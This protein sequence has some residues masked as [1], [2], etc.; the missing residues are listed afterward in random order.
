MST[1]GDIMEERATAKQVGRGAPGDGAILSAT[2]G[3]PQQQELRKKKSQFYTEVFSYREP[4]LSPKERV[5]K[6][7]IVTA[8]VRTNVIVRPC[9]QVLGFAS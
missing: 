7:S 3:T 9:L 1:P 2:N 5:Y 8:E 6:E 4:N